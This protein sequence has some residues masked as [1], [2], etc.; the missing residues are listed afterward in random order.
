MQFCTCLTSCAIR[1]HL[2]K[3]QGLDWPCRQEEVEEKRKKLAKLQRSFQSK[4]AEAADLQGS[5][6]REREDLLED[7]YILT[8]QI[9]LK[10]LLIASYIPPHHQ[11]CIMQH[12]TWDDMQQCWQIEHLHLA[13]NAIRARQAAARQESGD[14]SAA[15]HPSSV[16]AE[17]QRPNAYLTYRGLRASGDGPAA[18]V[19]LSAK[20]RPRS[21]MQRPRSSRHSSRAASKGA[22]PTDIGTLQ[23]QVARMEVD[24]S[25]RDAAAF[26]SARGLVSA[27]RRPPSRG[28][29]I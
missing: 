4:K 5:F 17:V 9:K 7:I 19:R 29:N 16:A 28:L 25:K 24:R 21:G 12:C 6:Q 2:S 18:S 1:Q 27:G 23:D 20:R 26:P 8:R 13:G 11:Q 15:V 10:D 3:R 14:S 22:D